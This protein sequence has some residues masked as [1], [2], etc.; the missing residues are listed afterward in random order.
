M[1]QSL[2][3]EAQLSVLLKKKSQKSHLIDDSMRNGTKAVVD[4]D[5]YGPAE[6]FHSAAAPFQT[7]GLTFELEPL[8]N[9]GLKMVW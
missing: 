5:S 3:K 8:R 2:C 1:F 7:Q 9:G 4:S 6:P